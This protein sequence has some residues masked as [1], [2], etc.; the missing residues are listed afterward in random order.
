MNK[1]KENELWAVLLD[2][3]SSEVSLE[4]MSIACAPELKPF[5]EERNLTKSAAV[6][7]AKSIAEQYGCYLNL[8]DC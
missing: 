1:G 4:P 3:N 6:I 8:D 2:R 7:I 5:V